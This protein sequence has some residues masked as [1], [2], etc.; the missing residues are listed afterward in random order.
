MVSAWN[1]AGGPASQCSAAVTDHFPFAP[2]A[3][4]EVPL[5]EFARLF[6]PGGA[7]DAFF[8]A[9]LK[10][11]VDMA[12]RPWKLQAVEGVSAPLTAADLMQF[13]RAAQI[14]DL[15]F[16]A[17]SAAL[18]RFD[19][20]PVLGEGQSAVRLEFGPAV[21][22]ATRDAPG[23]PAALVWPG[24]P[25]A[26]AAHVSVQGDKAGQ[27]DAAGA[28]AIFRLFG[29]GKPG[30]AGNHGS[31]LLTI[32]DNQARFEVRATPNPFTNPVLSEFRCPVMQ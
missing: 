26:T 10:P 15:Y 4:A 14:R 21:V 16:Q 2:A 23:R 6:G 20:L 32:G 25:P 8:N 30:A 13:Q 22:A 31:V 3:A 1:A 28:W 27:T 24:R 9:Q 17:G 18:V 29:R 11:Y 19:V 12:G 5:E 7:I